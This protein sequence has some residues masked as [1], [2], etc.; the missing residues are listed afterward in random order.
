MKKFLLLLSGLFA[1]STI[2]AQQQMANKPIFCAPLQNIVAIAEQRGDYPVMHG[3]TNLQAPTGTM[4]AKIIIAHN[5]ET[6]TYSIIE[7]YNT[8]WACVLALGTKLTIMPPD[9]GMTPNDNSTDPFKGIP[10]DPDK[11]IK[12]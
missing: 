11:G 12:L 10:I 4:A 2:Y 5:F 9:G 1:T 3:D 7:V 6:K 8:N